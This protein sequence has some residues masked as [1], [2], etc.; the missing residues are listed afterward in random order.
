MLSRGKSHWVLWR[1]LTRTQ[2]VDSNY[3][4]ISKFAKPSIQI[5]GPKNIQYNVLWRTKLFSFLLSVK[6]C[7]ICYTATCFINLK[8]EGKL[9]NIWMIRQLFMWGVDIKSNIKALNPARNQPLN[10]HLNL[11]LHWPMNQHLPLNYQG[12]R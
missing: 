6:K 8:L 5:A 10:T 7:T 4:N 11:S 12:A 2:E 1:V 9:W 3:W